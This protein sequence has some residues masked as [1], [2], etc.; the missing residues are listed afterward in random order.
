VYEEKAFWLGLGQ[1]F[2]FGFGIAPLQLFDLH[3]YP[4]KTVVLTSARKAA[5]QNVNKTK[6][7]KMAA[8]M[9][10]TFSTWNEVGDRKISDQCKVGNLTRV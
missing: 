5:M 10:L 8:F 3:S 6:I 2:S 9:I 4:S 7:E 1:S